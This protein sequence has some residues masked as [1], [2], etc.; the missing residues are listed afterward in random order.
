MMVEHGNAAEASVGFQANH[1]FDRFAREARQIAELVG[2]VGVAQ[3]LLQLIDRINGKIRQL[4]IDPGRLG[5]QCLDYALVGGCGII[6]VGS[7]AISQ[8]LCRLEWGTQC[9]D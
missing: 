5:K 4:G 7:A 9:C 6:D 2:F 8:I 3:Q 1:Q